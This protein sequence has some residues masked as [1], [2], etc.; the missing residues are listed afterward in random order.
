MGYN[1]RI[2]G[3]YWGEITHLPTIDPNFQRDILVMVTY[4]IQVL[5]LLVLGD[6]SVLL[7]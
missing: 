5:N 6:L 2:N 4:Y 7:P 3:I 1:L